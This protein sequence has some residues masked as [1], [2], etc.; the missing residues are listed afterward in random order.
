MPAK[1]WKWT[2]MTPWLW[3]MSSAEKAMNAAPM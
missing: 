1:M 3:W 2:S